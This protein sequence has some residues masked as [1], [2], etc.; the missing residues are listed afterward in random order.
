M[1]LTMDPPP[2]IRSIEPIM[3]A[4][5]TRL[6]PAATLCFALALAPAARAD[7]ALDQAAAQAAFR[8]AA[9]LYDKGDYVAACPKLAAA[10]ALTKGEGLGGELL[11]GHCY[12][13]VGKVASAWATYNEVAAKARQL[14]QDERAREASEAAAKLEPSLSY[15][16]IDLAPAVRDLAGLRVTRDGSEIRAELWGTKFP[17][18]PGAVTIEVTAPG[19]RAE[20]RVVTVAGPGTTPVKI[21]VPEPAPEASA[22]AQ[23]PRA[24]PLPPAAAP[25]PPPPPPPAPA[26]TQKIAGLALG[27]LG[28]AGIGAGVVLGLV[29]KGNYDDA[30][31]QQHCSDSGGHILCDSTSGIDGARTLGT[32]ATVTFFGGVGLAALGTILFATSPSSAPAERAS[33]VPSVAL[34]P[35]GGAMMWRGRF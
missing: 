16:E 14:H 6:V 17:V 4:L 21:D 19:K 28:I 27:G 1:H 8:D 22:P 2:R 24:A 10:V 5:R 33:L 7:D 32:V 15:V 25:A 30:F 13:K 11:L 12:E 34:A 35:G 31:A 18:D 26:S 23:P 20:K 3:S 9:A 29:A